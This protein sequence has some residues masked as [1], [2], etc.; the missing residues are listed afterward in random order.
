M[1]PNGDGGEG[2]E[3]SL[4]RQRDEIMLEAGPGLDLDRHV[5]KGFREFQ[6]PHFGPFFSK[7]NQGE[8]PGKEL[9]CSG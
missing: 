3:V 6:D 5:E 7:T 2:T 9:K 1:L 4:I 8:D